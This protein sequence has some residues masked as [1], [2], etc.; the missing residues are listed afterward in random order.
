MLA[1]ED[2]AKLAADIAAFPAVLVLYGGPSCGVC[3]AIQPKL[4]A[5]LAERFGQMVTRY[6]DCDAH[7][8]LAAQAGIHTRPVVRVYFGGRLHAER[9]RTFGV[10]QLAADIERPYTL[11]FDD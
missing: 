1:V 11:M 8:E 2:A 5:L 7:P 10:E 3:A 9:A 6:V 4:E